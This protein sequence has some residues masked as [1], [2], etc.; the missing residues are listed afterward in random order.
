M[1]CI[2]ERSQEKCFSCTLEAKYR[3]N[4]DYFSV[5]NN[6][7]NISYYATSILKYFHYGIGFDFNKNNLY[8]SSLHLYSD[9]SRK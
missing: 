3:M 8:L 1:H 4:C 9:I 5:T 6:K 7:Y 2:L